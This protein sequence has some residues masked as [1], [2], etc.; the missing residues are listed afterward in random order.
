[1]ES[2]F[3]CMYFLRVQETEE[4]YENEEKYREEKYED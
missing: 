1:M 4:I 3:Y 2:M